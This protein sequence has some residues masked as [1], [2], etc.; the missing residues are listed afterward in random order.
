LFVAN[1]VGAMADAIET[2]LGDMEATRETAKTLKERIFMQ[3]SQ[4][5]MVDGV[6]AG[7]RDAFGNY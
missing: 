1:S 6:I 3:F 5:A 4:R 2:A 7:Y